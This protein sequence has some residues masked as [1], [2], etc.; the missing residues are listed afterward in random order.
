[1][2]RN[3]EVGDEEVGGIR[4][5]RDRSQIQSAVQDSPRDQNLGLALSQLMEPILWGKGGKDC[6]HSTTPTR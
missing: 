4:R 3:V 1:M 2:I 5:G 6:R